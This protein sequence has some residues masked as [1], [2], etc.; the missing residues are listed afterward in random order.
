MR[1]RIALCARRAEGL[2]ARRRSG[3]PP[4]YFYDQAGSRAVRADHRSAGILSDP[5][6]A[7]AFC[8][9]MP[10]RSRSSFRPEPALV[11]F[12]SGSSQQDAHS[13]RRRARSLRPMCRSISAR[14]M[15]EQEAAQ[16]RQ[17]ISRACRRAG[18][19]RFHPAFRTAGQR[20]GVP[21]VGFFPARPSAISSRMRRPLPAPCGRDPGPGRA[22]IVGTDLHKDSRSPQRRL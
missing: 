7:C 5:Q 17:R 21:R 18:G 19:C 15:L 14:E 4:K 2:S 6:R 9:T 1:R 22:L 12:G 16:L 13:A 11:E 8:R 3:F 20:A 10:P